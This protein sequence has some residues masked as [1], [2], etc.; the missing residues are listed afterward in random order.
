[1]KGLTIGEGQKV[2]FDLLKEYNIIDMAFE[3]MQAAMDINSNRE[4]I[5]EAQKEYDG[6]MRLAARNIAENVSFALSSAFWQVYKRNN[7]NWR[8]QL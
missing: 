8:D 5:N 3:R 4:A 1:M 2:I 6:I 7:K